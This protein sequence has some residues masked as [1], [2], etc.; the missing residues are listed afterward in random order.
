VQGDRAPRRRRR[1]GI[2]SGSGYRPTTVFVDRDGTLIRDTGYVSS[3][4]EV[5]L[6][7]GAAE[8]VRL[9]NAAGVPVIV[10]TNQ[11]GI[12]RGYFDMSTY[13]AVQE[14]FLSLLAEAGAR[15]DATYVCPHSP[16][17]G[18]PCRKPGLGL[19]LSAASEL[20]VETAGGLYV[21]DSPRDV[22]PA[23]ELG[24]VGMLV[25]GEGGRYDG[26]VSSDVV[27]V[28]DFLTG[29]RGLLVAPEGDS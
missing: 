20:G 12:G 7:P 28:S 17:D 4:A 24:G 27:L 10:V 2:L 6:L 15:I 11:S 18:C 14:R 23:R 9:L 22:L 8:A 21:G 16:E 5:E 13:R 25:V 3:P 29:V 1:R 19:Y 26:E